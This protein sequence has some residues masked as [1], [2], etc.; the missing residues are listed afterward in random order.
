[1]IISRSWK[2][3]EWLRNNMT[4]VKLNST[5]G[6]ETSVPIDSVDDLIILMKNELSVDDA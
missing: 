2:G 4:G 1:M 3:R 6:A 5:G